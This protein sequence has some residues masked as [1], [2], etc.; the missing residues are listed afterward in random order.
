M[1]RQES[2]RTCIVT[3]EAKAP[4]ELIRFVLGPDNAV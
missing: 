1:P 4:A 3:H 2:E